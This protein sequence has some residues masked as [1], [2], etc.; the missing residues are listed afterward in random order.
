RRAGG[1]PMSRKQD[2]APSAGLVAE[3]EALSRE[4]A[5]K[6]RA[7]KAW[8]VV[9]RAYGNSDAFVVVDFALEHGL[10]Y[11]GGGGA[12]QRGEEARHASWVNPVDGSEMVWVPPGPFWVGPEKGRSAESK[13][14]SLAR[15]PVTNEQFRRFVEATGYEPPED[16]ELREHYLSHWED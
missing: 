11:E 2:G 1:G 8:P 12:P 9:A 14:F 6:A 3:L 4:P 13:G 5:G 7:R 16:D 15:H 10:A